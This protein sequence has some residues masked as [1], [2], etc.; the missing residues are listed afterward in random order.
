MIF[1]SKKKYNG[2]S[3]TLKKKAV[4]LRH[5]THKGQA[6]SGGRLMSPDVVD[7]NTNILGTRM[8]IEAH[9]NACDFH[10]LYSKRESLYSDGFLNLLDAFASV[11]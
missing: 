7:N 1:F 11:V 9:S 2:I 4:L 6:S 3:V 8:R 5:P 10:L